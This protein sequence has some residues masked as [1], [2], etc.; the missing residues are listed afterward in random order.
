MIICIR[1]V[2]GDD[3]LASPCVECG[4]TTVVHPGKVSN[5]SIV[6]CVICMLMR[7]RDPQRFDAATSWDEIEGAQEFDP[8]DPHPGQP[9]WPMPGWARPEDR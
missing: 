2:R 6:A 9:N 5:P 8:I 3:R 4:H 7:L 1:E